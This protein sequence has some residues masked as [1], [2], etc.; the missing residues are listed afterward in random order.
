MILNHQVESI[1][2]IKKYKS[3]QTAPTSPP[4]TTTSAAFFPIFDIPTIGFVYASL[5]Y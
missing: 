4:H 3:H 2:S 1:T 5:D